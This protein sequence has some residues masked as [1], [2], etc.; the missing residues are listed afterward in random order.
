MIVVQQTC[1]IGEGAFLRRNPQVGGSSVKD[2]SECLAGRSDTD[3]SVVLGVHVICEMFR[4]VRVILVRLK[5]FQNK[6]RHN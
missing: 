6:Q 1:D 5:L 3:G 4:P 2:D